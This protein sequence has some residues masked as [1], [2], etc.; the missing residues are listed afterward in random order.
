[1]WFN[2]AVA[3]IDLF[4]RLGEMSPVPRLGDLSAA[5]VEHHN[6]RM[7]EIVE[8]VQGEPIG[9]HTVGQA[10]GVYT[11]LYTCAAQRFETLEQ[12]REHA[13]A[14]TRIATRTKFPN[15]SARFLG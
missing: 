9:I 11:N 15:I 3:E 13:H 8:A 6:S 1:M 5:H 12:C 2:G 14:N 7:L 4:D 10:P